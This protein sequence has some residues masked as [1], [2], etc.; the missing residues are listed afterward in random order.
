MIEEDV[1][2]KTPEDGRVAQL[3]T[4]SLV[5]RL[6]TLLYVEEQLPAMEKVVMD[7]WDEDSP[8]AADDDIRQR[9]VD[10]LSGVF[11]AAHQE[12]Q[13]AIDFMCSFIGMKI[14]FF[15]LRKVVLDDLYK[16]HVKTARIQILLISIDEA[17][18]NVCAAAADSLHAYLAKGLLQAVVIAMQRVLLDG[19]PNRLFD[20]EDAEAIEEDLDALRNL[21]FAEGDGLPNGEITSLCQPVQDLITVLQLQTAI[22]IQNFK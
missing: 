8:D 22:L 6:N 10:W 17:L 3:T 20:E 15:D 5:V 1:V 2:L 19:G 14:I 13:R 9:S 12:A 16:H 21:F 4:D 7:R 11:E 18:G